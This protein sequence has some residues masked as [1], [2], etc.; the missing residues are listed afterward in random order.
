MAIDTQKRYNEQKAVQD[1]IE[2][3]NKALE[4]AIKQA[5]MATPSRYAQNLK[6][7]GTAD[8]SYDIPTFS[9]SYWG[10]DNKPHYVNVEFD[11]DISN[12]KAGDVVDL[13]KVKQTNLTNGIPT[14]MGA[15][16]LSTTVSLPLMYNGVEYGKIYAKTS[17]DDHRYSYNQ[18]WSFE[19]AESITY[20]AVIERDVPGIGTQHWTLSNIPQVTMN[21]VA[22]PSWFG[23]NQ[24]TDI[25]IQYLTTDLNNQQ[26]AATYHNYIS[27]RANEVYDHSVADSIETHANGDIGTFWSRYFDMNAILNNSTV[28]N[29]WLSSQGKSADA[30]I[31]D[32]YFINQRVTNSTGFAKVNGVDTIRSEYGI[33]PEIQVIDSNGHSLSGTDINATNGKVGAFDHGNS[34]FFAP[35]GLNVKQLQE[36]IKNNVPTSDLDTNGAYTYFSKQADDTYL[37]VTVVSKGALQTALKEKLKQDLR[38]ASF[39]INA[40][41]DPDKAYSNTMNYLNGGALQGMPEWFITGLISFDYGDPTVVNHTTVEALDDNGN[42]KFTASNDSVPPKTMKQGQSGIKV[43]YIDGS[44]GYEMKAYN[45]SI[46]DVGTDLTVSPKGVLGYDLKTDGAKGIPSGAQTIETQTVVNYPADGTWKDVYVVYMPY[47]PGHAEVSYH[48][49]EALLI[50]LNQL[51]LKG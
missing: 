3:K 2:A 30:N 33:Q 24:T 35:E 8:Q 38:N 49:N 31:Q 27:K 36:Y 21:Y 7:T 44:T 22:M 9:G 4:D 41:S 28:Y 37:A 6:V 32:I 5:A 51:P 34:H 46:G 20:Y 26:V 18:T 15:D 19:Q 1:E 17:S 25:Q 11:A 43:H 23:T 45:W 13:F 48:Y 14:T 47:S 50:A 10:A 40:D 42:V 12:L 29:Q 39:E 16:L